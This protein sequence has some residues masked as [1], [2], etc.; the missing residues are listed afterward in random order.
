VVYLR[1]VEAV[2]F[3]IEF[4]SNLF[5]NLEVLQWMVSI[6]RTV[7]RLVFDCPNSGLARRGLKQ[8]ADSRFRNRSV[9]DITFE[10]IGLTKKSPDTQR[11]ASCGA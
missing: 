9:E 5:L 6:D 4:P 11:N 2:S 8:D 1:R 7:R 3:G 10:D